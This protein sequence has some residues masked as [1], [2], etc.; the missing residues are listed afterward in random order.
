MDLRELASLPGVSGHEGKVREAL[1]TRVRELGYEPRTDVLGN[2]IVKAGSSGPKVLIDAHMDEV[3]LVVTAIEKNG[4]VRFQKVGGIDDRVLLS[5]RVFI[6][7]ERVPGVIGVK[8]IHMQE[9]KEREQV[10]PWHTLTIDIGAKSKEEAEK[11]V[12]VGDYIVFDTEYEEIGD[13]LVKSKALDDRVGCAVLL[14]LLKEKWEKIELYCVFAV[15]E[16]VGTRGARVAA[17]G[18]APDM[19]IAVEGTICSDLPGCEEHQWVTKLGGGAALSV[20]DRGSIPSRRM[21]EEL[22][23]LARENGIPVQFRESGAGAND[24]AAIQLARSGCPVA[25][26]SVPC[27]YIHSPVSLASKKDLESVVKLLV[28]F[29]RSVEGGFRP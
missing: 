5:K 21:V 22:L 9:P 8:A 7:R 26:V 11:K 2:V 10:I 1:I 19:G 28:L 3:G 15:Q 12:K 4:F 18:I 14:E 23:R 17:Y 6:G 20:M 29:L 16:E 13:D 27:R 24:A 25:S